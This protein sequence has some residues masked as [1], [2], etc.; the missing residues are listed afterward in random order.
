[1]LSRQDT[2]GNILSPWQNFA[3]QEV[4]MRARQKIVAAVSGVVVGVA[5]SGCSQ[6]LS[7]REKSTLGG[8]GLGAA[9]G[10]IIGAAVGNP[11]AGAAIGGALGG[12]GGAVVGDSMQGQETRQVEQQR[13][14]EEQR[15][16]IEQQRR[17]LEELKRKQR[18]STEDDEY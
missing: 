13:Q 12:V 15:R 10:A 6:P 2:S 9:T 3:K 7:T 4:V 11:G 14:M 18:R 16:E 17:E 8:V 5:L 1:L